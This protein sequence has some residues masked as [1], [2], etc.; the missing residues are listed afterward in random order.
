MSPEFQVYNSLAEFYASTGKHLEQE[1][2][3]TVHRLEDL[4]TEKT[5]SEA[6]ALL[7]RSPA[8]IQQLAHQLGFKDA[9]HFSRFFKKQ[10]GLSPSSFRQDF[11]SS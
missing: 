7:V 11:Q 10:T 4:I 2:D 1:L 5:I 6:Q 9:P 3:C 8:S